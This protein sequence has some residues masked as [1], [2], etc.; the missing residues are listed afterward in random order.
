MATYGSCTIRGCCGRNYDRNIPLLT[1]PSWA[2]EDENWMR[3]LKYNKPLAWR[4]K[5]STKICGKH[6]KRSDYTINRGLYKH[7]VPSLLPVEQDPLQI[8][9]SEKPLPPSIAEEA[10]ITFIEMS[11]DP[12]LTKIKQ[13]NYSK[14][15]QEI[16]PMEELPIIKQEPEEGQLILD[17]N[18]E[19]SFCYVEQ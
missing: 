5:K 15:K 8:D 13:E 3:V 10:K 2:L 18:I 1:I 16:L 7:A 12:H 19:Q 6:F 17:T 11:G 9:S 4:P 14:V